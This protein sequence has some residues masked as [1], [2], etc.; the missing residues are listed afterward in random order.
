VGGPDPVE[1]GRQETRWERG[2]PERAPGQRH[3]P[4]PAAI[5]RSASSTSATTSKRPK[6][7]IR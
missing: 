6:D 4:A 3:A 5:Q 1:T 7:G 2:P